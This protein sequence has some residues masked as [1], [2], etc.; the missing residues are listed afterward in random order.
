MAFAAQVGGTKR[1]ACKGP[2]RVGSLPRVQCQPNRPLGTGVAPCSSGCE[3]WG[4]CCRRSSLGAGPLI[5]RTSGLGIECRVAP[6]AKSGV[7]ECSL[8]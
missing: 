1:E 7:V 6:G 2:A 4:P 3:S 5:T 8:L